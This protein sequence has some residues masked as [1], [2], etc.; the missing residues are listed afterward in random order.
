VTEVGEHPR[1]VVDERDLA[2]P[3]LLFK[4]VMMGAFTLAS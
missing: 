2:D 4:N 3:P 1:Q